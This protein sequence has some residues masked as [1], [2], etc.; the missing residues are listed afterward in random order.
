MRQALSNRTQGFSFNLLDE[1]CLLAEADPPFCCARPLVLVAWNQDAWWALP[2][3][4]CIPGVSLSAQI[5]VGSVTL[6][7][8]Q[9]VHMCVHVLS[10][11]TSRNIYMLTDGWVLANK[12]YSGDNTSNRFARQN[13][14]GA[15]K[16]S[17][18]HEQSQLLVKVAPSRS[19]MPGTYFACFR[20]V[21]NAICARLRSRRPLLA[22]D[23]AAKPGT[24]LFNSFAGIPSPSRIMTNSCP[25]SKS[26]HHETFRPGQKIENTKTDTQPTRRFP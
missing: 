23:N 2:V 15:F 22:C 3:A 17:E 19:T 24:L 25:R 16:E 1:N 11:A 4:T 14:M 18:R 6:A 21:R 8:E 13:I 20:Y 5:Q 10:D 7:W 12:W 9:G 26:Q